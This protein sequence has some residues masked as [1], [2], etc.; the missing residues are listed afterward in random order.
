MEKYISLETLEKIK[1]LSAG[2]AAVPVHQKIIKLGEE[3]GE[4][5][6]AFVALDQHDIKTVKEVVEECCDVMNVAIDIINYYG[7]VIGEPYDLDLGALYEV[8][9]TPSYHHLN[10][11]ELIS[12]SGKVAQYFL[13]LDG[14]KNVSKSAGN[15][16]DGMVG[17]V[18]KV[19]FCA[20]KTIIN[21]VDNYKLDPGFPKE[22]FAKKL[23][24]WETKQNNYKAQ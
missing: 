3:S 23:N 17:Q 1:R 5:A 14:A 16:I 22:I 13:K 20:H 4:I 21:V 6:E 8:E 11:L 18:I 15:T 2:D 24:K 10:I 12:E 19:I 7:E 9:A